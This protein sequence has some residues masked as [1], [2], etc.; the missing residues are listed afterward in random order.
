MLNRAHKIYYI[1]EEK[2]ITEM[3]MGQFLA[4]RGLGTPSSMY[5]WVR[6]ELWKLNFDDKAV[7]MGLGKKFYA[8]CAYIP[9]LIYK[10]EYGE[11]AS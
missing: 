7:K 11:H 8:F 5:M 3:E 2:G 6:H 9:E 1:A 10:K 4:D